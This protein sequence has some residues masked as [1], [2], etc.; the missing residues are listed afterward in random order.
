MNKKHLKIIMFTD[1]VG[2]SRLM[3]TDENLAL[4]L[5]Q[6]HNA[7]MDSA[8]HENQG[9]VIKT[10]GDAYMVEFESV[11]DAIKSAAEAQSQFKKRNSTLDAGTIFEIRIGIHL[12][13][14][15]EKDKDYFGDGVNIAQRLESK[16]LPGHI[17][18]SEQVYNI[19]QSNSEFKFQSVGIQ[20]LKNI[21]YPIE[22]FNVLWDPSVKIKHPS[23]ET[24]EK[25]EA[26]IN[27]ANRVPVIAGVLI[28]LVGIVVAFLSFSGGEIGIFNTGSI[29]SNKV[30]RPG[31]VILSVSNSLG[32]TTIKAP[33][34]DM[35]AN[36][37]TEKF[38]NWPKVHM[39][40]PVRVAD[41]LE[42]T[43]VRNKNVTQDYRLLNTVAKSLGGALVIT[44]DI[45][46]LIDSY[47]VNI[48]LYDIREQKLLKTFSYSSSSIE[49][50][51]KE[52]VQ[53]LTS[54]FYTVISKAYNIKLP[55]EKNFSFGD[56]TTNNIE[57]Y[58]KFLQ[59]H[60]YIMSGEFDLAIQNYE[61][62]IT[63][64]TSF[65]MAYSGIMCASYFNGDEARQEKYLK[66]TLSF[67]NKITGFSKEALIYQGNIAW[68]VGDLKRT[69]L[70]YQMIIEL[71]PDDRDGYLYL[72]TFYHFQEKD[73]QKSIALYQTGRKL[74]PGYF[75][76]YK[77]IASSM[78]KLGKKPQAIELLD[79]YIENNPGS[80]GSRQAKELILEFKM[81]L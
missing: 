21:S 37:I 68:A 41:E 49:S 45:T 60:N 16:A 78:E 27:K 26:G 13:D 65:A 20:D 28:L 58:G 2:Y 54:D 32:D 59:A 18:V 29:A 23:K 74:S 51:L 1:I 5:L 9:I 3:N 48:I 55:E 47:K 25:K 14:V 38:Y 56:L 19:V 10:I 6:E 8:I 67:E 36:S 42:R 35:I 7:I 64:D 34:G 72:G 71:Y 12:G 43:G 73:Y 50:I 57:A 80:F 69:K 46:K 4:N 11:T 44:G 76:F 61:E 17:F 22:V 62:A 75:P 24:P 52:G 15:I 31:L 79:R 81:S 40:S 77:E 39:I 53:A 70:K 66:K 30:K 33:I 63:L